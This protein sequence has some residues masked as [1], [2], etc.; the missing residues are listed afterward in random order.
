VVSVH[1]GA[2]SKQATVLAGG[3]GANTWSTTWSSGDVP[4]DAALT[5]VRASVS[6]RAGNPSLQA[7]RSVAIDTVAPGLT[8]APVAADNVLNAAEKAAGITIG[9]TSDALGRTVTLHWSGHSKTATVAGNG[10]WT[11]TWAAGDM[12]ADA[13]SSTVTA[14]VSDAAGNAASPATQT[15][16]VDTAAPGLTIGTV[17]GDNTVNAA[18][19]TAGVSVSGSSTAESGQTVTITWGGISQSATVGSDGQWSVQYSAAQVPADAASSTITANVSDSAGNPA[20]QAS[21]SVRIDT[22]APTI[23]ISRS[24]GAAIITGTPRIHRPCGVP[25]LRVGRA[26]PKGSHNNCHA[27]RNNIQPY[28][29]CTHAPWQHTVITVVNHAPKQTMS[30]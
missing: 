10:T 24:A 29:T 3:G 7:T 21:G 26:H 20:P 2:G 30:P 13:A 28:Q 5:T 23:A 19:K 9:G 27:S 25:F 22:A 16:R 18:E 1:W 17:A 8:L 11:T 14:S 4:A 6:D 12:P 15:V